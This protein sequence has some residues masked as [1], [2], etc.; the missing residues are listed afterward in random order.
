MVDINLTSLITDIENGELVMKE[1]GFYKLCED[2]T[3]EPI[4]QSRVCKKYFGIQSGVH[5]DKEGKAIY[6]C[7]K[8]E[9]LIWP[10]GS[11]CKGPWGIC[12]V[13][14]KLEESLENYRK[15]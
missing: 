7:F 12:P 6:G 11:G 10:T 9:E 14:K 2:G 8:Q 3:M 4:M 13:Y 15:L 5:V 1:R